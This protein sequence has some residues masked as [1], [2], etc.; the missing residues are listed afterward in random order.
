MAGW[1]R[2]IVRCSGITCAAFLITC[3]G[4]AGP[5]GG[6]ATVRTTLSHTLPALPGSAPRVTV[7][8]VGYGPGGSSPPHRHPCAVIGYVIN[9]S[10]RSATGTGPDTIY[11]AGDSFYEEPDALHRVSANA[12]N[13]VPVTFT[14][15]FLCGR[16]TLLSVEPPDPMP[17]HQP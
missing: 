14:A 4:V 13:E 3:G 15:S 8:E 6:G 1:T 5:V 17:D 12:S 2:W 10:L 16:D 9:G 11:R 7:L